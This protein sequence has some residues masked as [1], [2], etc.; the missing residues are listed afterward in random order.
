MRKNLRSR[1]QHYWVYNTY[2]LTLCKNTLLNLRHDLLHLETVQIP[3][4]EEEISMGSRKES[5][6]IYPRSRSWHRRLTCLLSHI[7]IS[8]LLSTNLALGIPIKQGPQP[9]EIG[10]LLIV[11]GRTITISILQI[12]VPIESRGV[13]SGWHLTLCSIVGKILK[14]LDN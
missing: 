8:D 3:R 7:I 11:I 6:A 13:E 10:S 9:L 5:G 12:E 4:K 1:R 2:P 14:E